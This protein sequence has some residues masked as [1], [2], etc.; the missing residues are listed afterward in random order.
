MRK[1]IRLWK[2]QYTQS[3]VDWLD[4][5][6]LSTNPKSLQEHTTLFL[7]GAPWW[8]ANIT[9]TQGLI[10]QDQKFACRWTCARPSRNLA[11]MHGDGKC[12]VDAHEIHTCLYNMTITWHVT[13]S[14]QSYVLET[15][16]HKTPV[17]IL[18]YPSIR[19]VD[20]SLR[21]CLPLRMHRWLARK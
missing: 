2:L 16:I 11:S 4:A 21:T 1:S 10:M 20:G 18:C 8:H 14:E 6:L 9:I 17:H 12:C 13:R 19:R 3:M 5:I 7:L 15:A